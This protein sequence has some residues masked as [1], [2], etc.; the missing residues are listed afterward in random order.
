MSSNLA[1]RA[2]PGTLPTDTRIFELPLNPTTLRA[3]YSHVLT[4]HRLVTPNS[5]ESNQCTSEGYLA[6]LF[7]IDLDQEDT[8]PTMVALVLS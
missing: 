2:E 5:E 6:V 1:R 8:P 7:H 3:F 4:H